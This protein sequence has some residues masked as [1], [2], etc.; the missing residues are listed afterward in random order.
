MFY[1]PAGAW[2]VES[3]QAYLVVLACFHWIVPWCHCQ[4]EMGWTFHNRLGGKLDGS[5]T[6]GS[7]WRLYQRYA[8]KPSRQYTMII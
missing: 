7:S 2:I 3:F 6:M 1:E 8:C 4:Y 5:S